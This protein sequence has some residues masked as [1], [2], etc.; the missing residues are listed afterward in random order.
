MPKKAKKPQHSVEELTEHLQRLQAE[1]DN[2]RRRSEEQRAGFIDMA[3]AEIMTEIMPLLD[4]VERAASHL[5]KDLMDNA[6][7]K[8][9]SQISKQAEETLKNLG[10]VKIEALGQ[11]FDP[12]QHEAVGT[13][14]SGESEVV[15]E[16]L[17]PGYKVG[18]KVLRP[19]VVKVGRRK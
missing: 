1:F 19:A 16:Q 8:G 17:R 4:N 2:F 18:E 12:S 3:K 13:D 6:W 15:V 5:P 7:A 9:V 14:D 10:V 11:S